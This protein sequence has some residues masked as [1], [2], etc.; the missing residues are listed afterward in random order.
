MKV[1]RRFLRN[2]SSTENETPKTKRMNER[3]KYHVGFVLPQPWPW[4]NPPER[5]RLPETAFRFHFRP[6]RSSTEQR[7][8]IFRSCRCSK[9]SGGVSPP[10][11]ERR[12]VA[13][14]RLSEWFFG[15]KPNGHGFIGWFL[16]RSSV[17]GKALPIQLLK[18][19]RNGQRTSLCRKEPVQRFALLFVAFGNRPFPAPSLWASRQLSNR[20]SPFQGPHR[21][22]ARGIEGT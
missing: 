7:C 12:S 6:G 4:A 16:H 10:R 19:H 15:V 11:S 14:E 9:A 22:D 1:N 21:G 20:W 13:P 8:T 2:W 18:T 5:I 3:I 17:S